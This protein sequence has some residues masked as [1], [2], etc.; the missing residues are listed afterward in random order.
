[1][2]VSLSPAC[3]RLRCIRSIHSGDGGGGGGRG[4]QLIPPGKLNFFFFSN[5]VL[6]FAGLF[7]CLYGRT[8]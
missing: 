4:G 5:I 6:K 3:V 2:L 1:M 7:P 8:N